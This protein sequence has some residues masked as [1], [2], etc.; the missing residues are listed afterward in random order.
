M[1][2]M[3]IDVLMGK[4]EERTG[5]ILEALKEIEKSG[6]DREHRLTVLETEH[7]AAKDSCPLTQG[8]MPFSRKQQVGSAAVGGGI[9]GAIL[10]V[11]DFL[12]QHY[13]S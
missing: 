1:T 7:K 4:I 13:A 5:A 2:Q 8:G 12:I 10:V 11:V 9:V 6:A 3:E